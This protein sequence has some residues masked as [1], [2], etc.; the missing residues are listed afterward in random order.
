[1]SA[2]VSSVGRA[3][4]TDPSVAGSNPAPQTGK[5][6]KCRES[7]E[8]R[9]DGEE[10]MSDRLSIGAGRT[11][12]SGSRSAGFAGRAREN[13]GAGSAAACKDAM[14]LMDTASL[15]SGVALQAKPETS[16]GP[17]GVPERQVGRHPADQTPA[18]RG[19]KSGAQVMLRVR[20][21]VRI[22][23][24]PEGSLVREQSV[25]RR[26]GQVS[27]FGCQGGPLEGAN[28]LAPRRQGIADLHLERAMRNRWFLRGGLSS[29]RGGPHR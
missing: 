26:S 14:R 22:A 16:V 20:S 21:A 8:A 5:P 29:A 4:D 28:P 24:P 11:N 23:F 17:A 19:G 3:T 9:P 27:G 6:V 2:L 7:G 15:L 12:A 25:R 13:A 10:R 1:M 18:G